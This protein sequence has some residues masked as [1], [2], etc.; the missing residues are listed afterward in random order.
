[1]NSINAGN[2]AGARGAV[3]E[4]L[5]GTWAAQAGIT[6]NKVQSDAH[7]WDY[8]LELSRAHM[9]HGTTSLDLIPCELRC[10]VQVKVI[11][12]EDGR[13]R[14]KLSNWHR[15]VHDLTPWFVLVIVLDENREPAECFLVHIDASWC[16]RVLK[17]LRELPE[18]EGARLHEHHVDVTWVDSDRL[19]KLHGQALEAGIRF[20]TGSDPTAYADRKRTWVQEAGYDEERHLL[21]IEVA[22][23][24]EDEAHT[25]MA[26]FAIGLLEELPLSL[27][28]IE[29]LRF[30]IRKPVDTPPPGCRTEIQF[31][32]RLPD[33][34]TTITLENADQSEVI[35]LRCDTY[36]SSNVFPDLPLRF[37]K[38]RFAAPLF[39]A[40]MN[41]QP[42]DE[43]PEGMALMTFRWQFPPLATAAP[44]PLVDLGRAARA[45]LLLHRSHMAP[46]RL[47]VATEGG[48][49]EREGFRANDH[50]DPESFECWTTIDRAHQIASWFR[51]AADALVIPSSLLPQAQA[52]A[53]LS[54]V[55]VD[56]CSSASFR[57]NVEVE[58]LPDAERA[59]LVT[60]T[61]VCIGE[62]VIGACVALIGSPN[63]SPI[64]GCKHRLEVTGASTR[65]MKQFD[66]QATRWTEYDVGTAVAEAR[67]ALEDEGITI[68]ICPDDH[69]SE[70]AA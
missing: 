1:M 33:A 48:G 20:H 52:I 6:V 54:S 4:Y 37:Q 16:G 25:M 35:Q 21:H 47:T 46:L 2:D 60:S 50:L 11:R 13:A 22:A 8:L 66:V 43:V 19:A 39:T 14:I 15:M 49:F 26:D 55:I 17:R 70:D 3:G 56:K 24:R 69:P 45:A 65:I 12:S 9:K 40:T 58:T 51:L 67:A 27:L 30:G 31:A 44:T 10:F 23:T 34:E 28:R 61:S 38:I 62:R 32:D 63:W 18:D 53:F 64:G 36:S 7:G 41:I 5:L 57:A 68:V 42:S 29:E 59:A